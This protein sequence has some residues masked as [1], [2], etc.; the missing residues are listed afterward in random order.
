MS[1]PKYLTAAACAALVAA[2]GSTL[3]GASAP[4]DSDHPF[5][6]TDAID[7]VI[8]QAENGSANCAAAE[9]IGGLV[10][11]VGLMA[12]SPD[13]TETGELGSHPAEFLLATTAPALVPLLERTTP[14]SDPVWAGAVDTITSE[15]RATIDE[16]L[17]LGLTEDDLLLLQHEW[18]AE[19]EAMAAGLPTSEPDVEEAAD[20]TIPPQF[21]AMIDHD[22]EALTF[23]DP[24]GPL[25]G[26]DSSGLENLWSEE[27]PE[28]AAT[29]DFNMEPMNIEMD[30][31]VTMGGSAPEPHMQV[32]VNGTDVTPDTAG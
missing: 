19:A 32:V 12:M 26:A 28:T 9:T 22:F 16:L 20:E 6:H 25:A 11:I 27:C 18:T 5:L 15:L 30:F 17:G 8:A 14:P 2:G 7:A 21:E 31:S 23:M 13:E 29:F 1:T 10:F 3:A 4:P 24:D